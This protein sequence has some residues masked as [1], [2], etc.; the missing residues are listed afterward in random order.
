MQDRHP[1]LE[2]K[3]LHSRYGS[4][5]ILRGVSLRVNPGTICGLLGPNGSG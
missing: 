2:T 5:E 4:R 3:N 1:A